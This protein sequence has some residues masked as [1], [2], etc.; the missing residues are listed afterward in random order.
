MEQPLVCFVQMRFSVWPSSGQSLPDLFDVATYAAQNGWDGLWVADHFMP[1]AGPMDRPVLEC[2]TVLAALAVSVPRI[3]LGSL[4]SCNSYRHPAVLANMAATVD[5][6]SGGRL[7]LGLGA[8]WQTNEHVAYG[9][10]LCDAPTRLARLGEACA[11]IRQLVYERRGN[12]PGRHYQLLDAPMEPKPLQARLPLLVGGGGERVTLRL[13]ARWADEWNTWGTPDVLAAKGSVLDR[14]CEEI[15]RDPAD[16]ERSAQVIV[17]LDGR[18]APGG[19]PPT[20]RAGIQEMQEI[21]HAYVEAGV[22]EFV[23][24]DWNLGTGSARSEALDRFLFEVA[25]PFRE[26]Q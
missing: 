21:L 15:G 13:A 14:H 22:S 2:W 6:L 20:V 8:G 23:L 18:G 24:P 12:Y 17:D 1:S 26:S 3:R 5:Q 25:L 10:E 19:W 7:V 4:V 11:V 16:L 9:I